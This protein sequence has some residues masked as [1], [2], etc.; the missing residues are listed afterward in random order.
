[1][2]CLKDSDLARVILMMGAL[3]LAFVLHA[4]PSVAESTPLA[5][6]SSPAESTTDPTP[7]STS[8]QLPA[9]NSSHS[10]FS[11]AKLYQPISIAKRSYGSFSIGYSQNYLHTPRIALRAP[12]SSASPAPSPAASQSTLDSSFSRVARGVFFGLE[13]GLHWA[14]S[15]EMASSSAFMLGGYVNGVAAQDYS[16]NFGLRASYLIAH[17]VIPSI[18][19]SY[20]LQH[21]T[22]PNDPNQYNIHGANFNAGLFVNLMRGF[23][24]KAEA[25]YAYPLVV[26]RGVNAR[27]YGEPKFFGFSFVV[28]VCYYDFSI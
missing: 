28:S 4:K 2:Y 1:M 16:L 3:L 15:G 23:G 22:F 10:P 18:G 24:I 12:D 27:A 21:I 13:R 11:F 6:D 19:I 14:G 25:S 9:S 26:L 20:N 8:S 17:Y 5:L 7:K